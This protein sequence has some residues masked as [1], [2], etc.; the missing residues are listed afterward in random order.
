MVLYELQRFNPGR[1]HGCVRPPR[2]CCLNKEG[3]QVNFPRGL[4]F[5]AFVQIVLEAEF[6]QHPRWAP[7]SNA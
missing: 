3:W 6:E 4:N 2:D 5:H 7:F 1:S